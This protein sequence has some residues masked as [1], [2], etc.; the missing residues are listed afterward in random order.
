VVIRWLEN[1]LVYRPLSAAESWVDPPSNATDVSLTTDEG[2]RIHAWFLP[3]DADAGAVLVSHGNGGNLSHREE[4]VCEL[5]RQLG[6]SVLIYDYPGYG[7]S[8]GKS[9]EVGCYVAGDA[10]L[11]WLTES[12]RVPADRVVLLGE[13]LGGGVAVDLATRHTH[14]AL[15]LLFTF[16]SLPVAAQWHFPWLPCAFLMS[17]RFDNMS[18]I[19]RC[20]RPIFITHGTADQVIPFNHGQKLFASAN[21]PK[22]FLP[23]EGHRHNSDVGEVFY[24]ELKRFLD[25]KEGQG[26]R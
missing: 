3:N 10:A 8:E 1:R 15:V 12:R 18:K 17:N 23:L 21:E 26:G 2:T 13:S 25:E 4:L 6:R 22:H 5:H 24:A 14:E 19:G 7:K 11:C 20:H 9:S 16:T